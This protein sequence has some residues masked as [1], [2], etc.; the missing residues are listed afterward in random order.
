M[1][2]ITNGPLSFTMKVLCKECDVSIYHLSSKDHNHSIGS[3]GDREVENNTLNVKR[4]KNMFLLL[5]FA[6]GIHIY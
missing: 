4:A 5:C 2:L 1:L 6:A 3:D